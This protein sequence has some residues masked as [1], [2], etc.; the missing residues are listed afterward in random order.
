LKA[1]LAS[2]ALLAVAACDVVIGIPD[3]K[4]GAHLGCDGGKC[5]C[6]AGWAD[7]DGDPE[8]GCEA[9]LDTEAHCG[10]C[11]DVCAHGACQADACVCHPGF[12]DCDGSRKNG[13]EVELAADA[14]SCGACGHDCLGGACAEGRCQ[15]VVLRALAY[16]QSIGVAG[17][18][19]TVTVCTSPTT[20]PLVKLPLGGGDLVDLATT[21]DCGVFQ[22]RLGDTVYWT[23]DGTIH[24]SPIA[25]AAAPTLVASPADV[26]S[27]AAAPTHLYW[28]TRSKTGAGAVQRMP[29]GGGAV[30]TIVG[31]PAEGLVVD[32]THAYWSDA[33]GLH[34]VA[35]TD[36]VVVAIAGAQDPHAIAIDGATLYVM[37]YA[38]TV[39]GAGIDVIPLDG[40]ATTVVA[41]GAATF[42]MTVT[43]GHLYWLDYGDGNVYDLPL[44]G[45][46]PVVIAEG[47]GS[48]T[49]GDMAADATSVYWLAN[50]AIYRWA[51]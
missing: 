19:L 38:A 22:A 3:R 20:S 35:H 23:S 48:A 11:G 46:A 10:A 32:D 40:S 29:I 6:D 33:L 50:Q 21:P 14:E 5:S 30:E 7:C 31:R 12:V 25:A 8:N 36:K 39:D 1:R 49:D 37:D 26:K 47:S 41:P 17:D 15:P 45:G 44:A 2:L 43:G 51:R 27:I 9:A 24:A 13:C 16:P 18:A 34:A 4:V 42:A 28:T